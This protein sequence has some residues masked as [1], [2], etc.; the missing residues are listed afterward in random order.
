[1]K[2]G[3]K[4]LKTRKKEKKNEYNM[5]KRFKGKIF[6]SIWF[7]L[8]VTVFWRNRVNLIFVLL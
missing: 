3:K 1:M 6:S 2:K 5:E 8:L 7:V 4:K